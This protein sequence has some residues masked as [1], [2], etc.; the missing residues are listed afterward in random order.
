MRHAEIIFDL[1]AHNNRGVPF[2]T[3][4][5]G[6]RRALEGGE[7]QLGL[8]SELMMCFLRHLSAE[9]AME[10]LYS[11]LPFREWIV[12]V[13]LD[14]SEVG[15]PPED[16]EVVFDEA[17]EHGLLTVAHAGEEGRECLQAH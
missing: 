5:T 7:Q 8:S 17:R 6:I 3:V 9:A 10:T 13:G 12:A 16:Y 4:I 14:S 2:E 11:S 1:Q 15:H